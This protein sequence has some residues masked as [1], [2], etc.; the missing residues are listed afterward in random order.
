VAA[1]GEVGLAWQVQEESHKE[2]L[3]LLDR[4]DLPRVI[5]HWYS[6]PLNIFRE[7]AARGVYFTV[8]AEALHSE[9]IQTIAQE[10]PAGRLLTETDNPG[11]PRGFIGEPGMPVLLKD[12]VRGIAEARKTTVEAIVQAVQANF[13]ELIRDDPWLAGRCGKVLEE[14]LTGG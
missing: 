7:L 9:H 13:I 4:Y 3:E 1:G 14:Q 11:G 5:V 12:V 10:I 6:G 8:G 2:V